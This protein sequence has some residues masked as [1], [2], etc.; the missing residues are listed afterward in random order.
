MNQN[1]CALNQDIYYYNDIDYS[2]KIYPVI[3]HTISQTKYDII[4]MLDFNFDIKTITCN[5]ITKL[6][7]KY[8]SYPNDIDDP[9]DIV[10][11]RVECCIKYYS[12]L[13]N[14]LEN[15]FEFINNPCERCKSIGKQN[16][17][18]NIIDYT[19][20]DIMPKPNKSHNM[21]S[22][23]TKLKCHLNI[24]YDILYKYDDIHKPNCEKRY[25]SLF[26]GN[27]CMRRIKK[28]KKDRYGLILLDDFLRWS[29]SHTK[30]MSD[31]SFEKYGYK[32]TFNNK[33]N[34]SR[35]YVISSKR[36]NNRKYLN[37]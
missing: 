34:P 24:M 20:D 16:N 30:N 35:R 8:N 27:K 2:I 31:I 10:E 3:I 4:D 28:N 19:I 22:I 9:I 1:I 36:N 32:S 6:N 21:G 7:I 37:D 26:Q 13:H 25:V 5:I 11:E 14:P 23:R 15:N 18:Y 17:K 33:S 12:Y 29:N